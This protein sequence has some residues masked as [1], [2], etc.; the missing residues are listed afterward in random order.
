MGFTDTDS[1]TCMSIAIGLSL[2]YAIPFGEEFL[3]VVFQ[4]FRSLFRDFLRGFGIHH[5]FELEEFFVEMIHA[6]SFMGK[7]LFLVHGKLWFDVWIM[8]DPM[9]RATIG[10]SPRDTLG[11]YRI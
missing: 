3:E 9:L 7:G 11:T 6:R 1:P 8:H 5:A 2:P 4:I 10:K